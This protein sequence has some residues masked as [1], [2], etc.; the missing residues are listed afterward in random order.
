[1]YLRI[2]LVSIYNYSLCNPLILVL[3]Y[4]DQIVVVLYFCLFVVVFGGLHFAISLV[5][6]VYPLYLQELL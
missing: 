1:M 6:V 3:C 5:L 4:I 2:V